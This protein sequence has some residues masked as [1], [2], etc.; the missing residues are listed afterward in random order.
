M[1]RA[2]EQLKQT[3]D[4]HTSTSRVDYIGAPPSDRKGRKGYRVGRS[5][6]LPKTAELRIQRRVSR[7]GAPAV[8]F[9][10]EAQWRGN[11]KLR[12]TLA[13]RS[14]FLA[15][16]LIIPVILFGPDRKFDEGFCKQ[17]IFRSDKQQFDALFEVR[18]G[19]RRAARLLPI[20]AMRMRSH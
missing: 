3:Q 17:W 16:R 4:P 8:E 6:N 18:N 14:R 1:N 15:E 20:V 7:L 12:R 19:Q 13:I 2:V 9:T 5:L 11:L 10:T